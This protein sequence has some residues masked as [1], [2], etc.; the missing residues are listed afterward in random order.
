MVYR[1]IVSDKVWEKVAE[2]ADY[3]EQVVLAPPSIIFRFLAQ[4]EDAI[5]GLSS[6]PARYRV[7]EEVGYHRVHLRN[8][9]YVLWFH[10]DGKYVKVA[11]FTHERM[12]TSTI[13]RLIET[14]D[15]RSVDG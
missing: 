13:V 6:M 10:I 2:A 5:L 12:D 8:Y 14:A 15:S 3:Y 4:V 9:P 7:V 1:L 11:A